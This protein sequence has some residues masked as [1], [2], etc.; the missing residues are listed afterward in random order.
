MP[1]KQTI[2]LGSDPWAAD[3]HKHIAE[4][5][6]SLEH[7]TEEVNVAGAADRTAYQEIARRV[8]VNVST[9]HGS[10]GIVL[11]G[12]GMGVSMVANMFPGISCA[13]CE[14]T[15]A[16][17][18]SRVLNNAN[19]L[20]M[21]EFVTTPYVAGEIVKAFLTTEF[22]DGIEPDLGE[23]IKGWHKAVNDMQARITVPSWEE[24]SA[25]GTA[26]NE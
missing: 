10:F 1:E 15:F 18:R 6:R 24:A 12:T 26:G 7:P 25:E 16:A 14:N 9:H 4:L 21:G 11:C 17:E 23:Q 20:A 13:L 2:Y 8:A 22:L 19:V 5:C 3:L